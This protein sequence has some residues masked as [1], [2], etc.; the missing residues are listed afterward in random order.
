MSNHPEQFWPG[1]PEELPDRQA[2]RSNLSYLD[3]QALGGCL[4]KDFFNLSLQFLD[5]GQLIGEK[6]R[7]HCL[8]CRRYAKSAGLSPGLEQERLYAYLRAMVPSGRWKES[9]GDGC[10]WGLC[11]QPLLA[12]VFLLTEDI[13]SY[14]QFTGFF[15]NIFGVKDKQKIA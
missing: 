2:R 4:E 13:A 7:N 15:S 5:N 3:Y 10:P 11:D 1:L 14:Q 9:G 6:E 12:E 8:A